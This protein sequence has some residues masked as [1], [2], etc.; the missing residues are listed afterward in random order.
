MNEVTIADFSALSVHP[1]AALFPMLNDEELR[2]LAEDIRVHGLA[3]AIVVLGNVLLDGRNRLR[4]CEIANVPPRF[5]EW[6]G[7]GSVTAWIVSV[8]LHRRH[9]STSQRA[10]VAARAVQVFAVEAKGRIEKGV[11]VAPE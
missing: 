6:N 4:A 8:N 9:L 5:V 10:M 3:S 2:E 1:A 7:T 11:E